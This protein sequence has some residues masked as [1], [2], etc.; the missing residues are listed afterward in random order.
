MALRVLLP[1]GS[2]RQVLPMAKG[3]KELGCTVTTVQEKSSDLG[4]VTR[5]ADQKIVIEGIDSNLELASKEYQKLIEQEHFDLVIPLSDFS[6]GI[7]SELKEY[8]ETVLGTKVATNE[9]KVFMDAFDKLNTMK[10]CMKNNLSCP[11]TLDEVH[12]IADVPENMPYPVILKPRSACGSIGLH[13]AKNRAELNR[14]IQQ[15]KE[16]GLGDIL[17]QEFIPQNGRQY[18]GHFVLDADHNVKTAIIAEKCRW[19]PVDGGASTL[20][21]TIHNQHILEICTK[22]LKTIG[23]V[24][25]CDIDLMEDPRDGSV[26]IIEI[27]AR[28]SA[29]VKLCFAAGANIAKQLMQLYTGKPV[30]SCL[31][32]KDDIRLRCV[33]TDFLWFVK[34]PHRFHTDP[35]WFS[36]KNTTD[37]IFSWKDLPVFFTFSL[38]GLLKYRREMEKRKR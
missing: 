25:Y 13:L 14:F 18:N 34:S 2:S 15:S 4:S 12:S 8:A 28:I 21:R 5:Y 30:D 24:G 10:I 7:F 27:N 1:E 33:H 9:R 20:C 19:F 35:N 29:N 26:R 16:E 11:Y 38:D 3:F 31:D 37:Q 6:A 36:W 32:Y 23:W 17:I 22:L